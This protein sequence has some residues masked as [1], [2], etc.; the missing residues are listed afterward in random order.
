M[1]ERVTAVREYNKPTNL[2][3]LRRFLGIINFYRRFI[4]DAATTQTPLH[5]L[6]AGAKKSDKRPIHWTPELEK[7]FEKC[8]NQLATS[9]PLVHPK[10]DTILAL[11]TDASDTSIAAVLEQYNNGNWE[12]LGFFS[13]KLNE[14][15]RKYSVYD[16]ELLAIYT[17]LKFFRFMVEGRHVIIKTDHEP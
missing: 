2:A 17:S 8:K 5:A 11:S 14:T 7:A 16:R 4:K 12:P 15:Q 10:K 1:A 13:R 6:L 3:E 9:S